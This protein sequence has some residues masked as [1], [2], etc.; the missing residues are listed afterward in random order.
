MPGAFVNEAGGG[1]KV[2][3]RNRVRLAFLIAGLSG[4]ALTSSLSLAPSA[5]SGR[6]GWHRL[7]P[8]DNVQDSL[9]AASAAAV[10][11]STSLLASTTSIG[12]VLDH[13]RVV[14]NRSSV[15]LVG[16]T[17]RITGNRGR[18]PVKITGP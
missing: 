5:A 6:D 14:G 18:M 2:P 10:V 1:N 13:I 9:D 8:G 11:S 12:S 17:T 16:G 4:L 3:S 7:R 15:T